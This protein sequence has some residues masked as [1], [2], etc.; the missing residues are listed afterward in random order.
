M[1]LV[2]LVIAGDQFPGAA[3]H[4]QLLVDQ[5]FDVFVEDFFFLSASALNLA[6]ADS[7]CSSFK[8]VAELRDAVLDACRP[9]VFAPRPSM[10][11]PIQPTPAP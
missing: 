10:V 9:L 7:N 2:P 3:G 6:K 8:P 4:F 5:R 1:A 11:L